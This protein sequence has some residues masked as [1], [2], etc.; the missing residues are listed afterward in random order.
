MYVTGKSLLSF[1]GDYYAFLDDK[2][3][4]NA[5]NE[6]IRDARVLK[7]WF[8]DRIDWLNEEWKLD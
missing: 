8:R 1:N 4:S 7:N 6:W 2:I 3:Q 5:E